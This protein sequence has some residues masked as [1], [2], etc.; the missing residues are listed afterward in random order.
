MELSTT[1]HQKNFTFWNFPA[2]KKWTVL[3][4]WKNVLSFGPV[5][6]CTGDAQGFDL[7]RHLLLK[8]KI[9]R[10]EKI[11]LLLH[12]ASVAYLFQHWQ[13][14]WSYSQ[15]NVLPQTAAFIIAASGVLRKHNDAPLID[16]MLDVVMWHTVGGSKEFFA[17][18][19]AK[20]CCSCSTVMMQGE[21]TAGMCVKLDNGGQIHPWCKPLD[22]HWTLWIWPFESP[23]HL[24]A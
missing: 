14:K 17:L 13:E 3:C 2:G 7:E 8:L 22:F 19:G 1:A 6:L 18:H 24:S 21:E 9:V 23:L 11:V 20:N 10:E 4:V 15:Q 12:F 5:L 16:L